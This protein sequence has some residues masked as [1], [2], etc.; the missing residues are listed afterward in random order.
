MH[1][2]QTPNIEISIYTRLLGLY[3]LLLVMGALGIPG[4]GSVLRYLALLP[5]LY[6]LCS[7]LRGHHFYIKRS[8]A[9]LFF[10]IFVILCFLSSITSISPRASLSR[11]IS[12]L[13][14]LLM[15][16]TTSSYSFSED[17]VLY[18]RN[19]LVWASRITAVITLV[20]GYYS[21][22]RL[23]L[24]G[25]IQ[26]DPNYL[27][28]YFL[29][30]IANDMS[31]L[32]DENSI[33]K[34][35]ISVI[36][37]FVYV[38]IAVATGSRGGLMALLVCMVVEY[39]CS[40]LMNRL[41]LNKIVS[42]LLVIISIIA[43]ILIVMHFASQQLLERFTVQDVIDSRGAGRFDIWQDAIATYKDSDLL[44]KLFGYGTGT[45]AA[46]ASFF[47][48]RRVNVFHNIFLENLLELGAVGLIVYAIYTISFCALAIKSKNKFAIPILLGI[49]VLS[50]ST[51]LYTFK[52]YW[53]I[54][55]FIICL[56]NTDEVPINI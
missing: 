21:A 2:S 47:G 49:I 31:V 8:K 25:I 36:E 53:D 32:L 24:R 45:A 4:I 19:K 6:C 37:L 13:S 15:L 50:F 20:F 29:F 3:F 1:E 9:V 23:L 41:S 40:A 18:L 33:K 11:S 16:I 17:E 44:R 42:Q 14:F 56:N 26:E 52:P 12:Q 27:C 34:K 39:I 55:L 51:S 28:A 10:T 30:G 48:F 43:I 46:I 22:G 5:V 35:A 38:Y 54:L 7:R